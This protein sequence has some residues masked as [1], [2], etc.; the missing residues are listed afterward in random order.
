MTREGKVNWKLCAENEDM[1][2]I[3]D[4][5]ANN[6]CLIDPS[7]YCAYEDG[8]FILAMAEDE[9]LPFSPRLYMAVDKYAPLSLESSDKVGLGVILSQ[10]DP[11]L[12]TS[13][14]DSRRQHMLTSFMK[15]SN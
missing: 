7:Y 2:A 12:Y 13:W 1:K 3:I 6:E 15:K 14:S 9:Q 8:Y 11:E 4:Q 10:V 5:L